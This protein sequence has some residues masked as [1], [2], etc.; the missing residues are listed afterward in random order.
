MP[1]IGGTAIADRASGADTA[2]PSSTKLGNMNSRADSR[3]RIS[4]LLTIGLFIFLNTYEWNL[5][6]GAVFASA[7]P[8]IRRKTEKMDV[9]VMMF[10]FDRQGA[11]TLRIFEDDSLMGWHIW[12]WPYAA[13]ATDPKLQQLASFGTCT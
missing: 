3:D 10:V 6:I 11:R 2:L 9:G 1:L 13:M 5:E 8:S 4:F 12:Q 7:G